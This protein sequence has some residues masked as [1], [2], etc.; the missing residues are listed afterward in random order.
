M[1]D[2]NLEELSENEIVDALITPIQPPANSLE[3]SGD[4]LRAMGFRDISEADDKQV[5]EEAMKNIQ[6]T[7]LLSDASRGTKD[8]K[9]IK[10]YLEQHIKFL[11]SVSPG[12]SLTDIIEKITVEHAK[13]ILKTTAKQS[14]VPDAVIKKHLKTL[15]KKYT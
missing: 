15:K 14:D 12:K 11:E 7:K 5:M 3:E 2:K 13:A 6:I 10:D 1:E 8:K 9:S 4:E